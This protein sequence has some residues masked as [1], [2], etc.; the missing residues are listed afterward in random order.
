MEG[1]SSQL[2]ECNTSPTSRNSFERF[3]CNRYAVVE[4][5]WLANEHSSVTQKELGLNPRTI[6]FPAAWPFALDRQ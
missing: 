4:P 5:V 6:P 1:K 2:Y 3:D